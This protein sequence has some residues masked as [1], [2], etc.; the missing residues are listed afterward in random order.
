MKLIDREA[1]PNAPSSKFL[2]RDEVVK[3]FPGIMPKK[4]NFIFR[5]DIPMEVGDNVGEKLI[6]K[7][8][9]ALE[10]D[11]KIEKMKDEPE[12]KIEPVGVDKRKPDE[13]DRMKYQA[14]KSLAVQYGIPSRR[15]FVKKPELI[16]LIRWKK[17]K[18]TIPEANDVKSLK[19]ILK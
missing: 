1:I 7:Y 4:M 2:S 14:L 19:E 18:G 10:V 6:D 16:A 3:L 5:Y 9:N 12:L 17:E 8:P 15:T 13:L 11:G